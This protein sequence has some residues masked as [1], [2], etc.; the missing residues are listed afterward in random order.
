MYVIFHLISCNTTR[1]KHLFEKYI[2]IFIML[3]VFIIEYFHLSLSISYVTSLLLYFSISFFQLM[4]YC[5]ILVSDE[6]C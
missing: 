5:I 6:D 2:C 3:E 1:N 4:I